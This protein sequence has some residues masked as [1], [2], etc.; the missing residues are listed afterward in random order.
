MNVTYTILEKLSMREQIKQFYASDII[1]SP[2]GT[3]LINIVFI[4]PH[5]SV[6][7]CYPYFFY[8]NWFINTACQSLAH[9]IAVFTRTNISAYELYDTAEKAYLSG[10][11][12]LLHPLIKNKI[13]DLDFDPKKIQIVNAITDAI[14]Y[15]LRWRFNYEVTNMFSPIFY[16]YV[17]YN[18][19]DWN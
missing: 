7:E 13:K 5:S 18:H 6:I 15:T 2:H 19:Y 17:L 4:I 1:M 14:E 16:Y 8:E 9:Y 3:G 11:F 10:S 12:L